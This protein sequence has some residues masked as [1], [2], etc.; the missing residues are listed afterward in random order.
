M[1]KLNFRAAGKSDLQVLPDKLLALELCTVV[2]A[3]F[4][5][6]LA[7]FVTSK[8]LPLLTITISQSPYGPRSQPNCS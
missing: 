4:P 5:T 6:T 1:E 3:P 8:T 7:T 2:L